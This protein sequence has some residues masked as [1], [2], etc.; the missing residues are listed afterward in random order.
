MEQWG[1]AE[2]VEAFE[3]SVAHEDAVVGSGAGAGTGFGV[4][5]GAKPSDVDDGAAAGVRFAEELFD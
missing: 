5:D 2:E 4:G 3:E 1:E